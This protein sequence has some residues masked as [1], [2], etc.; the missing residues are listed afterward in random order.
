MGPGISCTKRDIRAHGL[1]D[2]ALQAHQ[3]KGYSTSWTEEIKKASQMASLRCVDQTS[4]LSWDNHGR[5]VQVGYRFFL[6]RFR[7]NS[8]V[9][10]ILK[11]G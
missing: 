11:A 10:V 9:M 2:G 6:F 8:P 7:I 5:M 4:F 1:G 3:T